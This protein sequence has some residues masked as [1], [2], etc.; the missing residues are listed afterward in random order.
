MSILQTANRWVLFFIHSDTLCLLI[1]TFSPFTFSVIER[2]GF[3]VIVVSVGFMLVVV[4]L[5]LCGPCNISLTESPLRVS[6]KAGLVVMNS[7]SFYLF[8]KTFI[9]PSILN[10]SVAGQ[11]IFGCILKISCH[12]FLACQVSVDRSATTLMCLPLYVKAHLSLAAFRNLSLSLY[13]A[14][15]TMI[16]MQIDS[17]CV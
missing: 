15:L 11:R 5:V 4:S 12:S 8:G 17:S 3:R 1:G 13:F 6:C 16:C 10:G 14:S 7:S 9:S 2:Y